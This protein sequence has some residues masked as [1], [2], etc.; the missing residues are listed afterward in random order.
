MMRLLSRT[1]LR[2]DENAIAIGAQTERQG[3]ARPM[4]GLMG[5]SKNELHPFAR[6]E[7]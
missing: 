1:G 4:S 7:S 3:L 6:I 5:T 2:Q